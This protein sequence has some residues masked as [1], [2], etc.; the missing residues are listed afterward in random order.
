LGTVTES[1][2]Y[3]HSLQPNK[4]TAF[5]DGTVCIG[6][7][8]NAQLNL[9]EDS[10]MAIYQC[11]FFSGDQIGYWENIKCDGRMPLT[12]VLKDRLESGK[13]KH[14][15]AWS[16]G[17]LVCDVSRRRSGNEG[18]RTSPRITLF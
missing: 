7:F 12:A 9:L 16:D 4:D 6:G 17:R 10:N 14:A 13:W 5:I 18:L 15:E 1:P 8:C 3:S 2:I 11:F